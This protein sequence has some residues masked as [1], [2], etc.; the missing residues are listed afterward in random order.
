MR[1]MNFTISSALGERICMIEPGLSIRVCGETS[2]FPFSNISSTTVPFVDISWSMSTP[3]LLMKMLKCMLLTRL[4]E[5]VS[6]TM[7][8]VSGL[9]PKANPILGFLMR[10]ENL[11]ARSMA[12]RGA[13]ALRMNVSCSSRRLCVS[14]SS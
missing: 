6:K 8:H 11:N 1:T 7:S 12:W 10:A 14:P 13:S 9:R 5:S 4:Y 2:C 3:E